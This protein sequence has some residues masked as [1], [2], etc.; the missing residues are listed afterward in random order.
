[1]AATAYE[2][3]NSGANQS[4]NAMTVLGAV[5]HAVDSGLQLPGFWIPYQ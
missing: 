3:D 2:R 4:P 1:M 5:F